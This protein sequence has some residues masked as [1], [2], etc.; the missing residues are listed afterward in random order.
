MK[1]YLTF[2]FIIFVSCIQNTSNAQVQEYSLNMSTVEGENYTEEKNDS[3]EQNNI[4]KQNNIKPLQFDKKVVAYISTN[5][6]VNM[7]LKYFYYIPSSLLNTDVQFP[8]IVCVPGQSGDGQDFVTDEILNMAKKNGFGIL[9]PSFQYEGDSEYMRGRSYQ[10]PAAWSGNALIE[11]LNTAKED[12]LNYSKLYMLG[13]SAGA[14]FSA[15]FSLLHPEMLK[16]CAVLASGG[17]IL[18]NK[19][20]DVNYFI[21]VGS[22]DDEFRIQNAQAFTTKAKQ[23]GINVTSKV[24][25]IG[26]ET[27]HEEINDVLK[28]FEEI[29]KSEE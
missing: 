29:S 22:S 5:N 19:Q 10:F 16:A 7:N 23:L 1:K 18:P 8:V 13:F 15:R 27:S 2:I 25:P 6:P 12:G 28:F 3:E 24:Y 4:T 17:R 21:G 26:H 11:M 9:A 20:N 14:Q